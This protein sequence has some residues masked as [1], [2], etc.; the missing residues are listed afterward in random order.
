MVSKG[1]LMKA[2]DE[3]AM[4]VK[5]FEYAD[6][7]VLKE[8]VDM[9]ERGLGEAFHGARHG[10]TGTLLVLAEMKGEWTIYAKRAETPTEE[11]VADRFV[12]VLADALY[13]N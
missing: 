4:E 1:D 9:F 3:A 6:E 2:A 11:E 12:V 10:D 7:G 13:D 5:S 8:C